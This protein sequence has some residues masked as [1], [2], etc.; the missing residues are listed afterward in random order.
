[1]YD[2]ELRTWN[3]VWFGIR[4]PDWEDED[5][6]EE[7]RISFRAVKTRRKGNWSISKTSKKP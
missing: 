7:D 4:E 2:V 3:V 6:E 5:W 1:M